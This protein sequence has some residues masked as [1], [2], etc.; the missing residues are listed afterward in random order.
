M[1]CPRCENDNRTGAKFCRACGTKLALVTFFE[2]VRQ[3]LFIKHYA[4]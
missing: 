4:K 2:T 3:E 1:N